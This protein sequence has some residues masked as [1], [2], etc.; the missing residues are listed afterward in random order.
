MLLL[1]VHSLSCLCQESPKIMDYLIDIYLQTTSLFDG[2][3]KILLTKNS[4]A[5]LC[6]PD[7]RFTQKK[8]S[9]LTLKIS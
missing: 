9:L 8:I 7:F 2:S 3:S 5:R 4:K 6:V 1:F